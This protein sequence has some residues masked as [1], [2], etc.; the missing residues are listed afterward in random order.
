MPTSIEGFDEITDG[1]LLRDQTSLVIGGP[2]SSNTVFALHTL[3]NRARQWGEPGI[4][5]AFEENARQIVTNAASFSWDLLT[6][7]KEGKFTFFDACLPADV[8]QSGTFDLSAMLAGL[9]AKATKMG[10]RLIVFDSID[11]LLTL[12]H[13]PF[14]E[15]NEIYRI[16]DWLSQNDLTGIITTR[17]ESSDPLL[18]NTIALCSSW[19]IAWSYF[20][21]ASPNESRCA[22]SS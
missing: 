19:R 11:V 7:E 9:K 12:L 14:S 13:D 3:V 18:L 10:A 20:V 16:R 22:N 8:V 2:G 17:I 5:V 1:G 4:F 15:Q 6:L 21:I